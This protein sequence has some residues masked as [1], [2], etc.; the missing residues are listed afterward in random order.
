MTICFTCSF[1]LSLGRLGRIR[2]INAR[3]S[4][5]CEVIEVGVARKSCKL[6]KTIE[7]YGRNGGKGREPLSPCYDVVVYMVY[8]V[9]VTSGMLMTVSI[10]EAGRLCVTGTNKGI[11]QI[12]E[13]GSELWDQN[14]DEKVQ[15][16]EVST[17]LEFYLHCSTVVVNNLIRH[18]C[19]VLAC[20]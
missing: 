1:L 18:S 8:S 20:V 16:S 7:R 13:L 14:N 10:Q 4:R 17:G 5:R 12:L 19:S 15:F 2:L 6:W 11:L 9:Q 3:E